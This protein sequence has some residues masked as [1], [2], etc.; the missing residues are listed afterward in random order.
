VRLAPF[1]P[2][3]AETRDAPTGAVLEL[4]DDFEALDVAGVAW[5]GPSGALA[6]LES[7]VA[8]AT[9]PLGT[10]P[11]DPEGGGEDGGGIRVLDAMQARGLAFDTVVLVGLNADSWPRPA[12]PDPFLSDADRSAL[13][14][15]IRRPVPLKEER[16]QE[17]RL[18]LA[19]TLGS[20]RRRL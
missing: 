11:P 5:P 18:I 17:E 15:R 10:V 20:A 16:L 4:L 3:A 19:L 13:R 7:A 12:R 2:A 8:G 6:R 9:L 14:N 1:L